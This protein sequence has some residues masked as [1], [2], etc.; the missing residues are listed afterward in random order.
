V[1]VYDPWIDAREARH[2]YGVSP[3]GKLGRKHY[4]VAIMAVGHDEFRKMGVR[5]VRKLL[6]PTSV[7]YDIKYVF[8]RG[9]VDGRL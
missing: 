3:L 4:D 9:Q 2:E 6:N 8:K 7:I 5:G 1:D